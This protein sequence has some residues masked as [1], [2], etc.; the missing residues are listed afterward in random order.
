MTAQALAAT[1]IFPQ[2]QIVSLDLDGYIDLKE[3][4][5]TRSSVDLGGT[6]VQLVNHAQ[7]GSM[8]LINTS[9]EKSAAIRL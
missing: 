8:I 9:G 4:C 2:N 7:L 3:K 5:H 6:M 1:P